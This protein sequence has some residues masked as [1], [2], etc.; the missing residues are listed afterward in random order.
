MPARRYLALIV[1]V[2]FCLTGCQT[3]TSTSTTSGSSTST[4]STSTTSS[5]LPGTN[6]AFKGSINKRQSET[7]R[8][9]FYGEVQ[10]KGTTT[11]GYV[12]VHI[13]M[14]NA[15]REVLG[16]NYSHIDGT[17]R[18]VSSNT[19]SCLRPGDTGA[20]YVGSSINYSDVASF[21]SWIDWDTYATFAPSA[22]FEVVGSITQGSNAAGDRKYSGQAKNKSATNAT[23][24]RLIFIS[25]DSAGKVIDDSAAYV[26][27]TDVRSGETRSFIVQTSTATTEIASYYYLFDWSE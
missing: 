8:A 20:F 18:R 6:I 17:V 22:S 7:G 5:T 14:K 12:K 3:T 11:V 23:F 27:G 9:D 2:L 13:T 24:V 19:N 1:F 25:K 26:T 21:E 15:S 10:N 4:T 16:T